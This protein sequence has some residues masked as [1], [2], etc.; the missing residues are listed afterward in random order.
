MKLENTKNASKTIA[1]GIAARIV[2]MLLQFIFR[3]A[4][5][6]RLGAEY[7]GLNSLFG[8]ILNILNLA[9]LG[10]CASIVYCMYKPIAE[11]NI[12]EIC[13]L[14]QFFKRCYYVIGAVV[15]V[16]GILVM[17]FLRLLIRSDLPAGVNLYALYLLVLA[18]TVA[19]YYMY[20]YKI[21]VLNAY[22]RV[23]IKNNIAIVLGIIQ[24][25]VQIVLI[26]I[27]P[28]YY[29]YLVT[30]IIFTLVGNVVTAR[31]VD[32]QFPYLKAE[33]NIDCEVRQSIVTK[34][35]GMMVYKISGVLSTSFD[36]FVIS[37]FLGLTI[38]GKL[39]NYTFISNSVA[40]IL[41]VFTSSI[42]AG[43]G[44]SL[45]L[46]NKEESVKEYLSI[47]FLY[48][49]LAGWCSICIV[50][51]AQPFITVWAGEDFLLPTG[52]VV[53][54]AVLFYITQSTS[55]T[56]VYRDASGI[57][58]EDKL[59]PIISALSNLICNIILVKNLGVLGVLL[60]SIVI[61]VIFDYGWSTKIL[62]K[63]TFQTSS[64]KYYAQALSF[65]GL[66]GIIG[67]I[68]Y[69]ITNLIDINAFLGLIVK[70]IVCIIVP[71]I[72]YLICLRRFPGY[73]DAEIFMR[74]VINT[75]MRMLHKKRQKQ[76]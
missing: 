47:A 7:L 75:I 49:W 25:T 9:E 42:V 33:G 40:S 64:K 48:N 74:K 2:I 39:N 41:A 4:F 71:N 70:G 76:F 45:V 67:F 27:I 32:K 58:D 17:P 72:F 52:I 54:V 46:K 63:T 36:S 62:F 50:C 12:K 61:N 5:I 56:N 57:W 20:S 15:L 53:E 1:T 24:Y 18:N 43:I 13:A 44:N 65:S 38:L 3:T 34:V 68:T 11:D 69:V 28:S 23:D 22:Q 35:K 60:S 10:I 26:Y 66:T 55:I 73:A 19:S 31:A 37:G 21:C 30:N 14:M 6:Y 8:S 51:L 29:L 59:R 16:G